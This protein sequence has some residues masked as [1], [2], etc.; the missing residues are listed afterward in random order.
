MPLVLNDSGFFSPFLLN[1][2]ILLPQSWQT[3]TSPLLLTATPRVF[4]TSVMVR[5][6]TPLTASGSTSTMKG[7][8]KFYLGILDF[9]TKLVRTTHCGCVPDST[10][11]WPGRSDGARYLLI[12]GVCQHAGELFA[13]EQN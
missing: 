2:L 5:C 3:T 12:P 11:S 8:L 10:H 7:L 9:D 13:W 1:T 6:T 4:S